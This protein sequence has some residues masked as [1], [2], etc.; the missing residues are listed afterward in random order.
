MLS[1][2][3][4]GLGVLKGNGIVRSK[5]DESAMLSDGPNKKK[6]SR[7]KGKKVGFDSVSLSRH[8]QV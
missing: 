2:K 5:K 4:E 1:T 3:F 7:S 8:K 6:R